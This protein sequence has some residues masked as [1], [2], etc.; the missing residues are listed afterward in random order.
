VVRGGFRPTVRTANYSGRNSRSR[1][2]AEFP[3]DATR[4]ASPLA[5]TSVI[6]PGGA[7]SL[8][9]PCTVKDNQQFVF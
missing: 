8:I 3:A 5:G 2:K 7:G 9:Q 4:Q 6:R 1:S